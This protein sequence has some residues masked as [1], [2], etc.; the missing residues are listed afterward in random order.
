MPFNVCN[1]FN[2]ARNIYLY[3]A[4]VVMKRIHNIIISVFEKDKKKAD[5]IIRTIHSLVPLDFEKEKISIARTKATGMDGSEIQIFKVFLDKQ[6]HVDRLIEHLTENLSDKAKNIILE[7]KYK[8][9]DESLHFF[10]RLDKAS[11]ERGT[12]ML[13]NSG[14]CYHI[15]MLMAAYPKKK[16][17]GLK[18]IES[19]FS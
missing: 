15:K 12:F 3:D 1:N 4:S 2:T 8:R 14:D 5:S 16:E 11:L 17:A 13:T 6:R 19:L 9:L 10:I 18:I 7:E